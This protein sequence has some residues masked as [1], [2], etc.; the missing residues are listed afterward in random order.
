MFFR[1]HVAEHRAAVPADHGRADGARDVVVAGRDIGRQRA[2]RIERRF[3][4]FLQLFLHVLLDQVHRHMAGTFDHHL[5]IVLPGDL[6][7]FAQRFEFG[8][9]C[10]VVGVGDRAR[11]QA[12]AQTEN[13]TS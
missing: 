7:Q 13:D 8:K 4:T 10:F 5:H 6:R 11:A 12:I 2:E 9:L 3:V 1:R